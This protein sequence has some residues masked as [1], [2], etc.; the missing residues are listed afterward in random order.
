MPPLIEDPQ[1]SNPIPN[2]F[3]PDSRQ[4]L[5]VTA[6]APVLETAPEMAFRPMNSSPRTISS[7]S[8]SSFFENESEVEANRNPPTRTSYDRHV[9]LS[10][11]PIV[12]NTSGSTHGDA[13]FVNELNQTIFMHEL[14]MGC[15][16]L[17]Q[18]RRGD[19]NM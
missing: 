14:A 19:S 18:L 3:P 11:D 7:H 10:P 8:S 9:T 6:V 13:S 4:Y 2:V 17:C 5:P 1:D 15:S 12:L 16:I